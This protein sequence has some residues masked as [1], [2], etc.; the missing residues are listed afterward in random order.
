[1]V[2]NTSAL[3]YYH[4]LKSEKSDRKPDFSR[5][6]LLQTKLLHYRIVAALVILFQITEVR[7]TVSHHLKKSTTRMV[8]FVVFLQMLGQFVDTTSKHSDL[9][10]RRASVFVMASCIFDGRRLY[11]LC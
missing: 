8:I 4:P 5:I 2:R 11:A 10:V 3:T 9:D 1:M 6:L 7:A